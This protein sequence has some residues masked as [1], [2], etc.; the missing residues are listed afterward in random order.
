MAQEKVGV[1]MCKRRL[2]HILG[3]ALAIQL[4]ITPNA[5]AYLDPGAG[6]YVIQVLIASIIGGLVSIKIFWQK[7]KKF[8]SDFLSK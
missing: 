3:S 4:A 8:F 5:F 2:F 7:I 1:T 6:S